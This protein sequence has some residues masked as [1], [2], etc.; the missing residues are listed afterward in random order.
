MANITRRNSREWALQFLCQA[1]ANPGKELDSALEEFWN[2]QWTVKAE[3]LERLGKEPKHLD[4]A[5]A[6]R[7]APRQLRE[8]A[9]TLIRG[10]LEHREE[11]D[12]QLAA[13]TRNWSLYRL[14][15]VERNVLRIAFFELLH[16]DTPPS[17]VIN[18]AVDVAKYFSTTEAGRFINGILDSAKESLRRA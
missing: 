10:V 17:V 12:G 18:E 13:H 2:Q 8:F 4:R 5:P 9:E 3:E 7:V 14:G 1:E 16:L 11:L 15:T 6:D